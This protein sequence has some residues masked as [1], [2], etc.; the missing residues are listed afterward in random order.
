MKQ[1]A[2]ILG[3][4]VLTWKDPRVPEAEWRA[5]LTSPAARMNDPDALHAMPSNCPLIWHG[6]NHSPTSFVLLG[7][8][9]HPWPVWGVMPDEAW[10]EALHFRWLALQRA[11]VQSSSQ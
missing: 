9:I 4:R 6:V 3:Y 1:A 5:A 8:H 10:R 2:E 11:L 7:S